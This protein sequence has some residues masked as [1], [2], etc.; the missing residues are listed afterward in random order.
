VCIEMSLQMCHDCSPHDTHT[1]SHVDK[2]IMMQ[3]MR[4]KLDVYLYIAVG[5][6]WSGIGFQ[7]MWPRL[8]TLLAGDLEDFAA[9]AR[10]R[11][12]PPSWRVFR[13]WKMAMGTTKI[14]F[15]L[16]S[17]AVPNTSPAASCATSCAASYT[18]S[19]FTCRPRVA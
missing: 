16:P 17:F 9:S 19:S 15:A 12:S 4:R 2:H 11:L 8:N 6:S 14:T 13:R 3:M 5:A 1:T 10:C 18:C 7:H